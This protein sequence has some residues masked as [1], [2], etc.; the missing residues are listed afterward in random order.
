MH[1]DASLNGDDKD[2]FPAFESLAELQVAVME[3]DTDF[4]LKSAIT[5]QI[6][7]L[8]CGDYM[9]LVYITIPDI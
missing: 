1:F 3:S 8:N 6:T 9:Y 4:Q 2:A 7:A 5:G